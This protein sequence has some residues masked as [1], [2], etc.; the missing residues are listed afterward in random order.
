MKSRARWTSSGI[1]FCL[2][3]CGMWLSRNAQSTSRGRMIAS[4]YCSNNL[5]CLG[6]H[7]QLK[8]DNNDFSISWLRILA[9]ESGVNIYDQIAMHWYQIGDI[10]SHLSS[11]DV[12]QKPRRG[13]RKIL[14]IISRS[15]IFISCACLFF[16]PLDNNLVR[17][18][19]N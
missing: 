7:W 11:S 14:S 5:L 8:M 17:C 15:I 19:I 2:G 4:F 10:I 13:T 12:N 18:R 3:F 6:G 9:S 1:S 16:L